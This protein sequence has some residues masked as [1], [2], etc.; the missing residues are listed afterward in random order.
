MA[1]IVPILAALLHTGIMVYY[2]ETEDRT[3]LYTFPT[4]L[5]FVM[6][7]ISTLFYAFALGVCW[8]VYKRQ[9][10]HIE[11]FSYLMSIE[12]ARAHHLPALPMN[13]I[14]N[15]LAW[16]KLRNHMRVSKIKRKSA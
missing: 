3:T 12:S 16:M 14:K 11:Y 6:N 15:V 2:Y 5:E 1:Y 7:F 13:R 4:I 8:V 10:K 9:A